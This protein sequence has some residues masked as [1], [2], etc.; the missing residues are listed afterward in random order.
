MDGTI[1]S[2]VTASGRFSV[3]KREDSTRHHWTVEDIKTCLE[4]QNVVVFAK[5]SPEHP[6]CGF[7]EK[8]FIEIE[9]TGQPFRLVDVCEDPSVIPA[10]KAFDGQQY[11]PAV[12]VNGEL[13][14][15]CESLGQM[16]NSGA[17]AS[18]VE[19]ARK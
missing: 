8:L 15:S 9:R 18:R 6:R 12:Y 17:F 2:A 5:G 4:N 7:S 10:L 16:L 3:P 19:K 14:S 1:K 13:V 11:L